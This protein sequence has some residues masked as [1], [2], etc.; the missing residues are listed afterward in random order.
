MGSYSILSPPVRYPEPLTGKLLIASPVLAD[1]PFAGAV[2]YICA[3]SDEGGAMGFIVNHHL[4]RFAADEIFEQLH[5]S[6]L[7]SPGCI[8]ISSGGPLEPTRGFVLHSSEWQSEGGLSVTPDVTLSASVSVVKN[9]AEGTGPRWALLVMGH[10]S[11]ISGQLEEEIL[12]QN[13]WLVAPFSAEI[14]FGRDF[15]HKWRHA[16]ASIHLD[17]SQLTGQT[18]R[19]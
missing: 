12:L 18:G 16:L 15:E 6:S 14:V 1:T 17:P 19:G 7:S 5:I 11:W 3:H 13:A 10:S 8:T 4:S 9:M 2:V